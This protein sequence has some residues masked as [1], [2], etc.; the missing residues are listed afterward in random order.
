MTAAREFKPREYQSIAQAFMLDTPRAALFAGMGLGKTV[1]TLNVLDTLAAVGYDGPALALGPLR[2]ARD[3]WP[4]ETRKWKHLH[5]MKVQPII[6]T[7]EERTRALR[8][9]ADL[10]TIN[11][12]NIVWLMEALETAKRGWPFKHVVADESTRLKGHRLVNGTKRAKALSRV[13]R[14]TDRWYN[15][16]GTPAANGL[17][18]L[19]G[20]YWFL[21]FGQRLGRTHDGFMQ[22][23]F[24]DHPNGYGKIPYPHAE[25]EIYE[26]IDDITLA[27]RPE[28][29]LDLRDPIVSEI[30]VT[31]PPKAFKQ[32]K[33]LETQMFTE[34]DC[35]AEIEPLNAAA[36]TQK[37]LQFSNGAVYTDKE[38]NWSEVHEAKLEALDSILEETN[39]APILVAYEFV[40]DRVRLLRRYKDAVD[41]S[42][43]AGYQAFLGGTKRIGVAHP[44]SMGHGIDGLQNVCNIAV[45]FGHNWDLEMRMQILERIGAVRQTQAGLDRDVWVYSIVTEGTLDDTVL[46]RH[47]SKRTVQDLLMEAMTK[48][49]GT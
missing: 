15:L 47:R 23:W 39:G 13:A 34:L 42:K 10:Y 26:R 2:V 36:K 20:Q 14:F 17:K 24:R 44:K 29:W 35:G 45:Y 16:T 21:D 38:G 8:V 18:D 48:R 9:K 28:D 32:Y 7:V 37:C 6:G 31:M 33:Q 49:R 4:A 1:T 22:R 43:P 19:W 3:T 5:G 12:D 25:R 41:I 46:E 11:Y 30:R 40:S 27:L